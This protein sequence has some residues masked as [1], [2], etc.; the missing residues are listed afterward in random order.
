VLGNSVESPAVY[1]ALAN[2]CVAD[3]E[4]PGVFQWVKMPPPTGPQ[5]HEICM[6]GGIAGEI[7]KSISRPATVSIKVEKIEYDKMIDEFDLRMSPLSQT[8]S[9]DGNTFQVDIYDDGEGG[10]ILEV[11]DGFN[12]STI[13]D[14]SFATDGD[15][16]S[17]AKTAIL[18]NGVASLIDSG[19]GKGG[20][21]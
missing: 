9:T 14:D 19:S 10:W 18:A 8:I 12:A 4:L 1:S 6:P 13:W 5:K 7:F 16:L 2:T 15:A 21:S 11:I 20:W 3:L 17:E